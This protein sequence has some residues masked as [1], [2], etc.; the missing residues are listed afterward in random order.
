MFVVEVFKKIMH[1]G[2][3][4]IGALD[5]DNKAIYINNRS[6]MIEKES[7]FKVENIAEILNKIRSLASYHHTEYIR[8][9]I[10][11]MQGS[12]K[13]IRLRVTDDCSDQH[14]EAIY[15]YKVN[16]DQGIKTEIEEY[17]YVGKSIKEATKAIEKEGAFKEEN[18]YEKM[19]TI[20]RT[21]NS[22]I[23]LDIYPFGTWIEIEGEIEDIWHISKKL[24][25][26]KE[27]AISQNADELYLEWIKQHNLKEMWDVRFGLNGKK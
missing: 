24:G 23:T 26:K 18:S 20:Y 16:E 3:K 1:T 4:P 2:I 7:K 11:G 17:L 21:Q 13:K 8:D 19:R 6:K 22:E 10:W 5:T 14:I 27:D 15:K 25:Y 12:T 9:S